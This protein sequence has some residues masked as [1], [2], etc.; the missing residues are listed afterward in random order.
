MMKKGSYLPFRRN[1]CEFL[2]HFESPA[3]TYGKRAGAAKCRPSEAA[4]RSTVRRGAGIIPKRALLLSFVGSWMA[5]WAQLPSEMPLPDTLPAANALRRPD[6][7]RRTGFEV[8][9]SFRW[10]DAR[11]GAQTVETMRP[12]V[13]MTSI[14]VIP[15][16]ALPARIAVQNNNTLR[17]GPHVVLS[18][19]QASN[20]GAFPD[21][22]L[23]ARTLSFPSRR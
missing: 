15:E 17:L 21:S 7:L 4:M 18:N 9:E 12:A 6:S 23:D 11:S 20:W 1:H 5:V 22:Y 2:L 16:E 10:H 19:G 8:P 3:G 13:T 14:R